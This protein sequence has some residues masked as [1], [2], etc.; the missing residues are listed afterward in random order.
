[1]PQLS[2]AS[3]LGVL[4]L[5]LLRR[6]DRIRNNDRGASAIEWVIISATLAALAIA[7]GLIIYNLVRDKASTIDI[8]DTPGGGGGGGGG[9]PTPP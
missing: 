1:M 2:L 7:V 9:G 6:W 5:E 3:P 4:Q 8:N